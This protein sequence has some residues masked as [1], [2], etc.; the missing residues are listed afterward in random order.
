MHR[1]RLAVGWS[2]I[3][4]FGQPPTHSSPKSAASERTITLPQI[5]IDAFDHQLGQRPPTGATVWTTEAGGFL[6]RGTFGKIWREAV[7]QSVRAPCRIHDLHH[8]HAV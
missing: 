2:L 7:A 3:E 4:A 8:T 6:R 5:A 1:R